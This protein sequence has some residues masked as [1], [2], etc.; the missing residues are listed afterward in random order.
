MISEKQQMILAFPWLDYDCLICDGSVRSGKTSIMTVA[1][2]DWAMRYFDKQRFGICGK[3]IESA[4]K[5]VT[6]LKYQKYLY[7]AMGQKVPDVWSSNYKLTHGFF[8]Q[9]VIQQV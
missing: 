8:R 5:N 3:T 6:I 9:F 7:N 4:M 1:F 2:V